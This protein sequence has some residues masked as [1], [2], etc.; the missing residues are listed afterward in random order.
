MRGAGGV[1]CTPS[2]PV[3][4][5]QGVR[6]IAESIVSAVGLGVSLKPGTGGREELGL[7]GGSQG[8]FWWV[9]ACWDACTS[10]Q[11]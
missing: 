3:P 5:G 1:G 8:W 11:A 2:P 7:Y 6:L 4:S 9:L 10:L